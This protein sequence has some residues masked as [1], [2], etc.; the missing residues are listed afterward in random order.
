MFKILNWGNKLQC[1]HIMG[2][3]TDKTTLKGFLMTLECWRKIAGSNGRTDTYILDLL[4]KNVHR[5][6]LEK[7]N[8]HMN[9]KHNTT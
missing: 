3:Y 6:T 7:V 5:E 4:K 9:N 1:F 8:Q 2:Y